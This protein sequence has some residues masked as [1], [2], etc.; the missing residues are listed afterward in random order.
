MFILSL[1]SMPALHF[2]GKTSVDAIDTQTVER[3]N[4]IK[5]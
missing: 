5:I 1:V 2:F 3:I 4:K